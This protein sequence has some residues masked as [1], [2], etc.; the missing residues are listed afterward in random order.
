MGLGSLP[1]PHETKPAVKPATN[2]HA[3]LFIEFI[4]N[5]D[6]YSKIGK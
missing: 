5:S 3:N 2:N 4:F 6:F 1:P